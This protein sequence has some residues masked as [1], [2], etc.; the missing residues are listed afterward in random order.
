MLRVLSV[1]VVGMGLSSVGGIQPAAGQRPDLSEF[2]YENLSF[3]GV[4]I[5]VGYLAPNN[6]QST[7][8]IGGRVDLGY[9]GPSFRI[10]PHVSYWSS[11]FEPSEV[12]GLEAQVRSL[13]ERELPAGTPAPAVSLGTIKWSDLALG[14]DGHYVWAVPTLGALTFAGLGTSAHFLNG[15]G[16]AI[17]G[18]FV[19]DLLDSWTVGVNVHGGAEVPMSDQLR[20]YAVARYHLLEDLRAFEIRVG[21]QIMFGETLPG[22]RLR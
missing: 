11:S 6:V 9:L 15:S 10:V 12:R 19:E 20:L 18:T 16:E 1:V 22:E 8:S 5:D 3:R 14:L 7:L 4:G 13:I 2:D 17:T 21:G